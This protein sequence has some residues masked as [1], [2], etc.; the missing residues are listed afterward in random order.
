MPRSPTTSAT[1]A[2]NSSSDIV[3]WRPSSFPT[4]PPSPATMG[5]RTASD[6]IGC[7]L[8]YVSSS[9]NPV[10]RSAA[11]ATPGS[12]RRRSSMISATDSGSI[13]LWESTFRDGTS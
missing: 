8:S 6:G 11:N 3:G 5:P 1:R 7:W 12:S 9:A 10:V 4:R 2:R 13:P